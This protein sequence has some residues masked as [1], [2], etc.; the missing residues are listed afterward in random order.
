[1]NCEF[2]LRLGK[3]G[4]HFLKIPRNLA[5]SRMYADNKTLWARVKIHEQINDVMK[6]HFGRVPDR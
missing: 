3:L 1:M 5:A 6:M 4:V 2:W